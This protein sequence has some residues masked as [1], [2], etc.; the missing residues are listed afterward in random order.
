MRD[1][2]KQQALELRDFQLVQKY[3]WLPARKVHVL[4]QLPELA[5]GL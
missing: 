5:A 3:L 4:A 1:H 2:R